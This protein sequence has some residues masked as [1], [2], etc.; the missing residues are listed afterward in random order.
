[1]VRWLC[2][3]TVVVTGNTGSLEGVVTTLADVTSSQGEEVRLAQEH[4][5]SCRRI[6]AVLVGLHDCLQMVFQPIVEL[7]TGKVVGYEALSRFSS[8][9]V[10]PP[11]EW[12]SEAASV[13]L[14]VDLELHA[15]RVALAAWN[16]STTDSY[17]SL[18]VS[19][20]TATSQRLFAFLEDAPCDRIV[21]ELTE[22]TGIEYYGALGVALGRLRAKG[23]RLAV[24][25]AGAGYSSLRHILNLRPDVIKLDIALTRG[26]DTDPARQ[27]LAIALGS[28][29]NEIGAILV[30]EGIETQG[31]LEMLV[32]L[33]LTH[34]QGF[35]LGRPAQLP[36]PNPLAQREY[37]PAV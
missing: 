37:L 8:E 12:F 23:L 9:P 25:D 3:N 32:R 5:A 35:H 6:E 36:E 26:I 24:D 34:G 33:G 17:L 13:G 18:N 27:A 2:A 16:H 14:G 28:F 20:E 21:L 15:L 1:V 7:V 11:N 10:R 22:H 30:A 19:P 4:Q 31:E 29:R